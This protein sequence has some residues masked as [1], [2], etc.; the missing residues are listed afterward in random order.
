MVK[1][2]LLQDGEKVYVDDIDYDRVS[3]YTWYKD[4]SGN[5]RYIRTVMYETRKPIL[6]TT[7][8]LKGS[9]QKVRNNDFTRNNLTTKGNKNRWSMALP[10]GTSKYK[11]VYWNKKRK[12]WVVC[13]RA[14][15][16]TKYLGAFSNEDE[17]AKAYNKAVDKYWGGQGYKNF[18]GEDNRLALN[19]YVTTPNKRNTH[20]KLKLEG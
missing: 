17:A 16:K 2:I 18:I 14:D 11:G 10:G 1:E 20:S 4:F 5:A 6:L 13:I 8:I 15:G 3:R 19:T 9:F 7:F 12:K